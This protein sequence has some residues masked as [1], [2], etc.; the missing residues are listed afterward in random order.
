VRRHEF[1]FK[2]FNAAQTL[3]YLEKYR[4]NVAFI[5][6]TLA[7]QLLNEPSAENKTLP[8]LTH[9]ISASAPLP[10]LLA[11]RIHEQF[12]L[13]NGII[14]AYG[15]TEM[16]FVSACP[17][18]M[19]SK[20]RD[21]AGLPVPNTRIIIHDEKRGI[22]PNGEVGEILVS[23]PT[24]F[25]HYLNDEQAT[26]D[27]ITNLNGNAWYRSGDVGVIDADGYLAIK[28]RKKDMIISG[29]ENVYCAEVEQALS[30]HPAIQQ[31]AV[32]GMPDEKWGEIV[33]AV[34]VKSPGHIIDLDAILRGCTS[35]ASY[36]RPREIICL[37]EL[38][39]NS[40]GK[41]RKDKLRAIV[42]ETPEVAR[43][44]LQAS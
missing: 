31:V 44:Q 22:L 32:V 30:E 25:S 24:S 19:L 16:L 2:R 40:F 21:T 6:P 5:V 37:D 12:K 41:V 4:I 17:P 14:N 42:R 1:L 36:K 11:E 39:R 15:I 23:G 29:G 43:Q 20:K 8:H 7:W 35:L 27:A 3:L 34:V 38:P 18:A 28:D 13:P 10:P 33:V 9:W 26:R